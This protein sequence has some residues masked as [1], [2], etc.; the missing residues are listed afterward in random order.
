MKMKTNLTLLFLTGFVMFN[1]VRSVMFKDC[2]SKGSKVKD[3]EVSNCKTGPCLLPRGTNA[4][5]KVSFT[6]GSAEAAT[7]KLTSVVHGIL[8]GIPVP[9]PLKDPDGCKGKGL[10]CPL[11]NNKDYTFVSSIPVLK[12]YPQVKL[13][14]KWELQD[15]NKNDVFCIELP[16]QL[17]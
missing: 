14:V 13:V 5:F 8:A 11:K 4:T 16:V 12:S 6:S 17:T 9:F 2:G 7:T 10:E 3:V 1:S 15:S